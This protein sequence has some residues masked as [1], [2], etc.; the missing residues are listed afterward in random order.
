[1]YRY[2]LWVTNEGSVPEIAQDGPYYLPLNV[3]ADS[4]GSNFYILLIIDKVLYATLV[5]L[6][7]RT[8]VSCIRLALFRSAFLR[9]VLSMH[10][11]TL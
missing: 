4:K 11:V 10:F 6:I 1:M 9:F 8:G 2:L 5:C 3:F 7:T